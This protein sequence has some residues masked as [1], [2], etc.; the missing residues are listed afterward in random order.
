MHY[1]VA[2]SKDFSLLVKQLAASCQE[3]TC[4]PLGERIKNVGNTSVKV[5]ALCRKMLQQAKFSQAALGWE[6]GTV[7]LHHNS[8]SSSAA[9]LDFSGMMDVP[10]ANIET[11]NMCRTGHRLEIIYH[12]LMSVIIVSQVVNFISY[13]IAAF[14]CTSLCVHIEQITTLYK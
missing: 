3:G 1:F 9:P 7:S 10:V 14:K 12:S 6:W 8:K 13:Q 11:N 2:A 4:H 5:L